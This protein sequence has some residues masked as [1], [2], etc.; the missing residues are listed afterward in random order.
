MRYEMKIQIEFDFIPPSVNASYTPSRKQGM[1]ARKE[2]NE[3]KEKVQW[4]WKIQAKKQG[5]KLIPK[6]KKANFKIFLH[7]KNNR[8]KDP[9]NCI[10]SSIDS[11]TGIIYEDDKKMKGEWDF[12]VDG[13]EKTILTVEA[14][15]E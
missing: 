4:L 11:A 1:V 10:K 3:F 2:L 14:E 13:T 12:I 5:W 7:F 6:N 8:H 9:Q 15:H